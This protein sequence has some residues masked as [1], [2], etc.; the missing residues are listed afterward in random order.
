MEMTEDEP[1]NARGEDYI[2][3]DNNQDIEDARMEDSEDQEFEELENERPSEYLRQCCPLC[4][5]GENWQKADQ[6]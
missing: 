2:M 4:F 1:I 3:S 5:G 6:L